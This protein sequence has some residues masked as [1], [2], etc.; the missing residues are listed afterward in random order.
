[1]IPFTSKNQNQ[2]EQNNNNNNMKNIKIKELENNSVDSLKYS[3]LTRIR[4]KAIEDY[5]KLKLKNRGIKTKLLK[6]QYANEINQLINA[7]KILYFRKFVNIIFD[8]LCFITFI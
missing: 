8:E 7:N 4:S 2:N 1:M 6:N 3:V 5:M